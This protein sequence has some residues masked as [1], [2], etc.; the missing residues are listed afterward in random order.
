MLRRTV[1]AILDV[2]DSGEAAQQ[3]TGAG[4]AAAELARERHHQLIEAV[5][6]MGE[7]PEPTPPALFGSPGADGPASALDEGAVLLATCILEFLLRLLAASAA[8]GEGVAA[9]L[10][11][12]WAETLCR[13]L[14]VARAAGVHRAAKRVLRRMHATRA[15]AYA[16]RDR[17]SIGRH[18]S[19]LRSAVGEDGDAEPRELSHKETL[20]VTTTL[21]RLGQLAAGRATNWQR[22]CTRTPEALGLL[23]RA[24]HTLPAETGGGRGKKGVESESDEEDEQEASGAS[25]QGKM[26][27]GDP[28]VAL[29]EAHPLLDWLITN[30]ALESRSATVRALACKVI[31]GIAAHLS[32]AG[33]RRARLLQRVLHVV[34]TLPSLGQNASQ[35]LEMLAG[36]V[37]QNASQLLEMLAGLVTQNASQLLEM[38]AG[39]VTQ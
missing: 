3:A 25:S 16:R 1:D 5:E 19:V 11:D 28:A 29:L 17:A 7:H 13:I 37:T 21:A 20:E 18:L 6:S 23:I 31:S 33:G 26:V 38:L 9:V 36:L 39:F 30:L 12:S 24:A 14:C 32:S 2:L 27:L 15:A 22:F 10:D 35:L 8:A 34:P 4:K